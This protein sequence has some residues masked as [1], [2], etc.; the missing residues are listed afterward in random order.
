MIEAKHT[1]V[2]GHEVTGGHSYGGVCL[3]TGILLHKSHWLFTEMTGMSLENMP[4]IVQT[5]A[6]GKQFVQNLLFPIELKL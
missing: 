5:W 1:L 6:R 2:K 3:L 4:L